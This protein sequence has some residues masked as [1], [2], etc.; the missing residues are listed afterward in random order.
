MVRWLTYLRRRWC[1]WCGHPQTFV[2]APVI[3]TRTT[4]VQLPDGRVVEGVVYGVHAYRCQW[5]D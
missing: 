2:E 3:S 1:A 4:D 5:H